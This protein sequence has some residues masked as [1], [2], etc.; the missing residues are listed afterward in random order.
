MPVLPPHD[1]TPANL[2][3]VQSARLGALAVL[4]LDVDLGID[5]PRR[6]VR[7]SSLRGLASVRAGVGEMG[8]PGL[9]L[10]EWDFGGADTPDLV[11]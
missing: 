5:I 2:P 3:L 10:K 8:L 4:P 9:C 1:Q 6:R 7:K 11:Q